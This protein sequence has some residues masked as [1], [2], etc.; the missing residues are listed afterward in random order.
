M[1]KKSMLRMIVPL[2]EKLRNFSYGERV[3]NRLLVS[4]PIINDNS[5]FSTDSCEEKEL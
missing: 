2:F 1:N 3:I 5:L 4:Y